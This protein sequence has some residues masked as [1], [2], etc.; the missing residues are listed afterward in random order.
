METV[1][2][3]KMKSRTFWLVVAWTSFVPL[4]VIAAVVVG[5]AIVVPIGTIVTIAG[6]I[7][8]LFM[9]GEKG[10]KIFEVKNGSSAS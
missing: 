6:T 10:R 5:P 4:A 3:N 9:A 1:K 7:T 2:Y 8:G